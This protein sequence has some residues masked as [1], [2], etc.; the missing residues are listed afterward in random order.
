MVSDGDFKLVSRFKW[1]LKKENRVNYAYRTV[2]GVAMHTLIRPDVRMRDHRDR[3]GLNN[4][5]GNIRPCS[6]SQNQANS[7]KRVGTTSRFKGVSLR[8]PERKWRARI[9][10]NGKLIALGVFISERKAARAYNKAAKQSFGKFAR[11]NAL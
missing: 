3:N 10:V 9:K 5:R 6:N 2:G 7:I 11:L 8:L 4:M 1:R